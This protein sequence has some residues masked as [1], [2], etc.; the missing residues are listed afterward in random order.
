MDN[1][2]TLSTRNPP[3]KDGTRSVYYN[4]RLFRTKDYTPVDIAKRQRNRSCRTAIGCTAK[5]KVV[6]YTTSRVEV[7]R[8]GSG[9]HN[10]D[11]T[12]IDAIKCNTAI[13][14]LA[15]DEI[16]KDYKSSHVHRN[17]RG[18]TCEVNRQI[19]ETIGGFNLVLKD[20]HNAG[21]SWLTTNKDIRL[22]GARDS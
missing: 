10:H 14:G 3:T 16:V 1:M 20:V 7:S 19:L 2:Y 9:L 12:K 5:L 4:C 11:L 21:K 13:R 6:F 18:I 15:V 17:L 22:Q 8:L